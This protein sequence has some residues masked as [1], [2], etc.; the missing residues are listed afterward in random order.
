MF[1]RFFFK[2]YSFFFYLFKGLHRADEVVM[3]NSEDALSP[4]DGIEEQME[5][6]SV[7]A[8]LLKG[9]LTERV[10][11]LRYST[12]HA[13]RKS[14]EYSYVSGGTR[15]EKKNGFLAYKGKVD[16]KEN[17][18]VVLVQDNN[19][20]TAFKDEKTGTKDFIIKFIY[21]FMPKF[22]LSSYVNKLVIKEGEGGEKIID[23]Y[24]SKYL[25]RYNNVHKFFLSELERVMK[26]DR[27]SQMLDVDSV[28]FDTFN[29]FGE[30]DGVTCLITKLKFIE[31]S[32]YD[33]SYILR[34]SYEK[35]IK[36]DFIHA[37]YDE[38]AERK[39]TNKEKR[40]GYIENIGHKLYKEEEK[41]KDEAY[42]EKVD[43]LLNNEGL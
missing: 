30:N 18:T 1:K 16:K 33:G 2:V 34:Y 15:A 3:G 8:D 9:E 39:Y 5:Q 11:T 28:R 38:N 42:L 40:D 43:K 10:R 21:E 19:K 23:F 31:T 20:T 17:E 35:I 6:D 29:A 25:E 7:W 27:R 4:T 12:A 36:D 41:E 14:K 22:N 24:F 13:S 26:G 32:E 37:V